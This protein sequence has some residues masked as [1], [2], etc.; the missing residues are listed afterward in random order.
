MPSDQ[1]SLRPL[2]ASEEAFV[3]ELSRVMLALPR[4]VDADIVREAGLPLSE[5]T[6]LMHLSETP[7]RAMRMS[8]L[9]AACNITLSGMTRVV[10]RLEKQG[11]VERT[12]CAE[13]GRGWNAALTDAGLT[14][15]EQAW[16][17]FLASVRRHLVDHFEGQDLNQLTAALQHVATPENQPG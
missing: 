6:P 17:E 7:G 14:R 12:K 1:Q 16:P 3:R 2:T 4:A 8:E 15:L 11:W 9:A 5:Y 13:D 10:T